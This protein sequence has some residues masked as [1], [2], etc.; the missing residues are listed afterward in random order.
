M[1]FRYGNEP[2]RAKVSAVA[3]GWPFLQS[4]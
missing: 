1:E 4:V 2:S 3:E